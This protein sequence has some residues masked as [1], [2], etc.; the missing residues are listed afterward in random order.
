M[1]GYLLRG[2]CSSFTGQRI[3]KIDPSSAT[4]SAPSCALALILGSITWV[5]H[6]AYLARGCTS[7][8]VVPQSRLVLTRGTSSLEVL[9]LE[10]TIDLKMA[11]VYK[12]ALGFSS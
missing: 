2:L 7:V 10:R 5:K 6:I 8:E 9:L 11:D 1:A 12:N 4:L 3:H